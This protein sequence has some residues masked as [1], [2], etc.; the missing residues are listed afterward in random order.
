M[1]TQQYIEQ[2]LKRCE[3]SLNDRIS[4]VTDIT[5]I[6]VAE[7]VVLRVEFAGGLKIKLVASDY[8][9]EW[10]LPPMNVP[11]ALIVDENWAA[12]EWIDGP[13]LRQHGLTSDLLSEAARFLAKLHSLEVPDSP[14]EVL[15]RVD[16]KLKQKLPVLVSN[17]IISE[18]EHDAI[19]SLGR[20]MAMFDVSL[21]HGDFSPDNLVVRRAELFSID[22]DRVTAHASDY[23]LVRA[24]NLWD[25]W[26]SSGAALF[27]AYS[28]CSPRDVAAEHLFFWGIFDLVYR[29]SY[30]LSRGETNDF[31][32]KR[33]RRILAT[34]AFR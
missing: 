9:Q 6:P 34:G 4:S 15:E 17:K 29:I 31:C 8:K 30:R 33:L 18:T 22:N 7:R 2:A 3:N 24:V 32:I 5:S 16:L 19:V 21:I 13:T 27:D 1:P 25:E 14:A 12:F 26:N 10:E 11:R 28:E 23:D 20:S